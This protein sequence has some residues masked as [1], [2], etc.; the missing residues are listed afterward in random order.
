[1]SSEF[2]ISFQLQYILVYVLWGYFIGKI[3][4]FGRFRRENISQLMH[5]RIS[6]V[7]A[8]LVSMTNDIDDRNRKFNE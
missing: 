5:I 3:P 2:E 4:L 1:M 7:T 6:F 8:S